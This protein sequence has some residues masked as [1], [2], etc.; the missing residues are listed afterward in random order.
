MMEILLWAVKVAKKM[1]AQ[2]RK[3]K[4]KLGKTVKTRLVPFAFYF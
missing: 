2:V 3:G 1:Y 4:G